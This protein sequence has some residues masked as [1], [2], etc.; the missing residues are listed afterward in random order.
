[1]YQISRLV[2]LK[3]WLQEASLYCNSLLLF[4]ICWAVIS[5][6]FLIVIFL[7]AVCTWEAPKY[8]GVITYPEW[9]HIV[10][11]V[12]VGISAIQIPLWALI[13]TMYYLCKGRVG[14]VTNNH[15]KDNANEEFPPSATLL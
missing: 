4:Q 10:G 14:Q 6:I 1:M 3:L 8:S 7:A 2:N 11:W 5:P 13:Q 9:A 12:L 15:A